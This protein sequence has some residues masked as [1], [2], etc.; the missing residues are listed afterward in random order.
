MN[1]VCGVG[2][3]FVCGMCIISLG[4]GEMNVCVMSRLIAVVVWN[5]PRSLGNRCDMYACCYWVGFSV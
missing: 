5:G 4:I 2:C 1:T 3:G